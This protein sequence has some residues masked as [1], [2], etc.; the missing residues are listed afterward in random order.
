[1]LISNITF[2]LLYNRVLV[3]KTLKIAFSIA[4]IITTHYLEETC[5][6]PFYFEDEIC[7]QYF[8]TILQGTQSYIADVKIHHR[9]F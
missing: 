2:I 3:R 5:E 7:F 6:T 8:F 1:M 4:K 9:G